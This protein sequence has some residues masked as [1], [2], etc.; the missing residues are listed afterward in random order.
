MVVLHHNELD[1]TLWGPAS[2]AGRSRGADI[3]IYTQLAV[4]VVL[5]V[6]C[7]LD[8]D[9]PEAVRLAAA[10]ATLLVYFRSTGLFVRLMLFVS[11]I[12]FYGDIIIPIIRLARG[13]EVIPLPTTKLMLHCIWVWNTVSSNYP[14]NSCNVALTSAFELSISFASCLQSSGRELS[15]Q[16]GERSI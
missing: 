7:A 13:N 9:K 1:R 14:V 2:T 12:V 16:E 4:V 11:A 10:G 6:T 3:A 8:Y 5:G 15:G